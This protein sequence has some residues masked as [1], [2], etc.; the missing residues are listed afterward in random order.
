MY[1]HAHSSLVDLQSCK[2]YRP[3]SAISWVK[4]RPAWPCNRFA[5]QVSTPETFY[6]DSA[7]RVGS[8]RSEL[9]VHMGDAV[10][11]EPESEASISY[12]EKLRNQKVLDA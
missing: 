12:F 2:D 7:V 4:S 9:A 1:L 3:I 8:D 10:G 6:S 11:S 5:D